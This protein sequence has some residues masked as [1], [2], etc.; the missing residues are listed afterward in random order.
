MN[1]MLTCAGR[2]NYL[3]KFFQDAL[4]GSG[5]VFAADASADAPALCEADK[6]LV[7]PPLNYPN[8][9]ETLLG[10]C[11]EY[12]I[13]IV[14]PL[15]DLELGSLAQY[16]DR[17]LQSGTVP[18][19]SSSN[20][21]ARC[22]DKW[23]TNEF[24]HNC[25]LESPTTF[26][27]LESARD[28]LRRGD[29][30]FPLVVKPR[31]GTA[32]IG[33]E[34]SED[35]EEL[36]LNY[37]LAK[38]RLMRSF[39]WQFNSADPDRCILIQEKVVGQEYGFEVVNDLDG[40]YVCTFVKQKLAMRAGETD[41][42]ITVSSRSLEAVGALIGR[43]LGHIGVLD[44]DVIVRDGR[45]YVIDMNPRF[46]GGYP[47]SHAAGANL[48]AALI[49]WATGKTLDPAW[50]KVKPGVLSSKYDRL[51]VVS[52]NSVRWQREMY[53]FEPARAEPVVLSA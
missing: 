34:Y 42:A 25:G 3:V 29:L 12:R 50:L 21:V 51:V 43:K 35:D 22:L 53:Q 10:L 5:R 39:L 41:R 31:W 38:K 37:G 15:N 7:V 33:N 27:S 17:F 2:R 4:K 47:F 26:L 24:L 30:R 48:P 1:A 52:S 45:C 11:R 36:E 49:A 40:R 16:R 18:V 28:A 6:G 8:Y 9:I 32:S 13:G 20:I 14:I 44:C 19:V 23:S 46:G